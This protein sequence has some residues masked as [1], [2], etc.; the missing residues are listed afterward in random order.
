MYS[1]YYRSLRYTC[2]EKV[3]GK[4]F[5]IKEVNK[6]KVEKL[7]K[8]RDVVMEKHVL[9]RAHSRLCCRGVEVLGSE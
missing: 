5:G 6:D 4:S 7:K 1:C 3:S 2:V 8:E 9:M